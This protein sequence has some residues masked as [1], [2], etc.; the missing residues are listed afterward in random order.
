MQF[1][2]LYSRPRF[3]ITFPLEQW[4]AKNTYIVVDGRQ[5]LE[6][7]PGPG[8][9]RLGVNFH[10]REQRRRNHRLRKVV[11]E[12]PQRVRERIDA[13][14]GVKFRARVQ[15]LSDPIH[16]HRIALRQEEITLLEASLVNGLK[17]LKKK[18]EKSTHT[19]T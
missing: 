13:A 10:G 18:D 3:A 17:V 14:S 6:E 8:L 11:Q 16:F 4:T 9:N 12:S 1:L 2:Y 15:A 7:A 5:E 19:H